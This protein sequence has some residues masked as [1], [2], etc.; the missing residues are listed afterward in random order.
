MNLKLIR[1]VS[2]EGVSNVGNNRSNSVFNN[3]GFV[4]I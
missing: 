1:N 2:N 3:Y 4:N